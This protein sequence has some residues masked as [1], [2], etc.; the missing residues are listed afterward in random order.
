MLAESLACSH[1]LVGS[2]LRWTG[3]GSSVGGVSAPKSGG[4]R[5]D[6]WPRHTKVVYNSTTC[7]LLGT[8]ISG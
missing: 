6:P 2:Y 3:L 5:F 1:V 8:Q 4:T 7:F